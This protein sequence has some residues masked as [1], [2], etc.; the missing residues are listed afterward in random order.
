MACSRPRSTARSPPTWAC[1]GKP[2]PAVFVE[3]ARRLGTAPGRAAVVEDA[4]AG[5]EAGRRGDFALVVGVDRGGNRE[6]LA[7]AGAD[8]VVADLAEVAVGD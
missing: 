8:A 6:A 3:A 1:P 4:I 5:V 7:A 2:D